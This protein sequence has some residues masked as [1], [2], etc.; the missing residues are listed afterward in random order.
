MNPIPTVLR[1]R[2]V[3]P[4]WWKLSLAACFVAGAA[5]NMGWLEWL[6]GHAGR[7]TGEGTFASVNFILPCVVAF[8]AFCYPRIRVAAMGGVLVFAGYVLVGLLRREPQPWKWTMP[9]VA[10]TLNPIFV[11]ASVSYVLLAATIAAWTK[12]Y[13]RVG[14]EEDRHRCPAC[15]YLLVGVPSGVCPECGSRAIRANESV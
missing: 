3:D 1:M 10:S 7:R 8:A 9:F 5:M 13:R 6:F 2:Y 12:Q 14:S 11:V 15:K 4:K